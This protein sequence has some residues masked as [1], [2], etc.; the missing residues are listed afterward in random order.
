MSIRQ[1]SKLTV[2][3][4]HSEN[5]RVEVRHTV[6]EVD[7]TWPGFKEMPPVLAT[8]M[9]VAFIEETCIMG[10]RPHLVSGQGTVGTHV[11]VN[12]VAATPVG[13]NVTAE[14]ELI[15]VEGKSLLFRVS[16]RD[17]I[18]LIGEG[19]HRRAIIDVARFNQRVREKS[20]QAH[21]T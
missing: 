2:G 18:G 20:N 10:L 3:L 14:V 7:T 8:A 9:M 12:H 16:C 19:T 15:E 17:N 21:T 13:M 1:E 11:D 6:P 5:L 4:C